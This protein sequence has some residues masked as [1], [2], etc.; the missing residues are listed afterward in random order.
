MMMLFNTGCLFNRPP[1]YPC[2]S[3]SQA[4]CCTGDKQSPALAGNGGQCPSSLLIMQRPPFPPLPAAL[5]LPLAGGLCAASHSRCWL[6]LS[7]WLRLPLSQLQHSWAV[8]GRLQAGHQNIEGRHSTPVKIATM[9]TLLQ[10]VHPAPGRPIKTK[11]APLGFVFW[12]SLTMHSCWV[13]PAGLSLPPH[14]TAPGAAS[15]CMARQLCPCL[16][17]AAARSAA[18]FRQH[19]GAELYH[20][21]VANVQRSTERLQSFKQTVKTISAPWPAPQSDQGYGCTSDMDDNPLSSVAIS[22]KGWRPVTTR[23][24]LK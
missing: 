2:M 3:A 23:M 1:P 22:E 24:C 16:Q 15:S 19:C 8:Q 14:R 11:P 9:H 12:V 17:T 7:Q 4:L 13:A 6:R 20:N 18:A 5:R 21:H 10:H